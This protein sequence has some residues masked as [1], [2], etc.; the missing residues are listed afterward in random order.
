M[1]VVVCDNHGV[2]FLS[3]C[4]RSRFYGCDVFVEQARARSGRPFPST[5]RTSPGKST[6]ISRDDTSS[7][8]GM[9]VSDKGFCQ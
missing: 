6:V 4:A 1:V 2:V 9:M 5:T 8:G 3:Q 7:G